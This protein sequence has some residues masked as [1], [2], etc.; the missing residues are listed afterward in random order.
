[1][2]IYEVDIASAIFWCVAK[3]LQKGVY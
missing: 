2:I 1:V 3:M